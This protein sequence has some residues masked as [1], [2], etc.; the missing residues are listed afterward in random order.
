MFAH[1]N[2]F[3]VLDTCHNV[4]VGIQRETSAGARTDHSTTGTLWQTDLAF[5]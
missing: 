1:F 3:N 4:I 5:L 2:D